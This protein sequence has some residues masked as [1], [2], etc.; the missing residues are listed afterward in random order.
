MEFLF[1]DEEYPAR[2]AFPV[3]STPA[4]F[5]DSR[6]WSR[7]FRTPFSMTALRWEICLP[8]ESD[9]AK[10]FGSTDKNLLFFARPLVKM[11]KL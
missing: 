8:S 4:A 7:V 9:E 10:L 6:L 3:L 2:L 1:S 5:A 11:R